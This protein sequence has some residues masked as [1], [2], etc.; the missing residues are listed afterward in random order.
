MDD[1]LTV[2]DH[3]D[4]AVLFIDADAPP[5]GEVAGQ[6]LGLSDAFIAISLDACNER[7]DAFE[8]SPIKALP[9]KV[10]IPCEIMPKLFHVWA[11]RSVHAHGSC[12]AHC[13]NR[14]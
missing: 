1:Q 6:G 8:R 4:E 12:E 11:P 13:R 5:A 3:E 2:L 9:L 14:P 10:L 7:I